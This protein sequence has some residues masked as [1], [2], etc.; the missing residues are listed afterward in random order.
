MIRYCE[1]KSKIGNKPRL[2]PKKE[3]L[4]GRG[5]LSVVQRRLTSR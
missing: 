5:G 3:T 2:G 1:Q 4:L